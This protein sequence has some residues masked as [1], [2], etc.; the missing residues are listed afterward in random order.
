MPNLHSIYSTIF[1]APG[2][3]VVE[4]YDIPL[5][6]SSI[7]NISKKHDYIPEK[8][9]EAAAATNMSELQMQLL[10]FPLV[11]QYGK[12]MSN[13]DTCL[14]DPTLNMFQ[15]NSDVGNGTNF[16]NISQYTLQSIMSHLDIISQD[17]SDLID[18]GLSHAGS[19]ILHDSLVNKTYKRRLLLDN[20]ERIQLGASRLRAILENMR[21]LGF[22]AHENTDKNIRVSAESFSENQSNVY[23]M[24]KIFCDGHTGFYAGSNTQKYAY[25]MLD[26]SQCINYHLV[27]QSVKNTRP[28]GLSTIYRNVSHRPDD[29]H[30]EKLGSITLYYV[31]T[32]GKGLTMHKK[33]EQPILIGKKHGCHINGITTSVP[34]PTSSI[35]LRRQIGDG[36]LTIGKKHTLF[37]PPV[38]VVNKNKKYFIDLIE[39][40]NYF[41]HSDLTEGNVINYKDIYVRDMVK[42]FSEYKV[43][44]QTE[45]QKKNNDITV[46][47]DEEKYYDYYYFAPTA[48]S[49]PDSV[50]EDVYKTVKK[51][52]R[53]IRKDRKPSSR[54]VA[55]MPLGTIEPTSENKVVKFPG[56][57]V[58]CLMMTNFVQKSLS[59]KCKFTFKTFF[60]SPRRNENHEDIALIDKAKRYDDIAMI[61]EDTGLIKTNTPKDVYMTNYIRPY[62]NRDYIQEE[63]DL[64]TYNIDKNTNDIIEKNVSRDI[65]VLRKRTRDND[66]TTPKYRHQTTPMDSDQTAPKIAMTVVEEEED[67]SESRAKRTRNM[68]DDEGSIPEEG[69]S[70]LAGISNGDNS[71]EEEDDETGNV[72]RDNHY[73][74][75]IKIPISGMEIIYD[76]DDDDHHHS[77]H[78]KTH[79]ISR[80]M[81][82][83]TI[84]EEESTSYRQS[85]HLREHK[86]GVEHL[87]ER[88][89]TKKGQRKTAKK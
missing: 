57:N 83:N 29:I 16:I 25:P 52:T 28:A 60:Q 7:F 3:G 64:T 38:P 87:S 30:V 49:T 10:M 50:A 59:K 84:R 69:A 41:A 48:T 73:K 78:N 43:K 79:Q 58:E 74:P 21:F 36:D 80:Q 13:Y 75:K 85:D 27:T 34:D 47:V 62:R 31:C 39:K 12:S 11:F 77:F 44:K 15:N 54:T 61:D 18:I 53:S 1:T 8:Y 45:Y 68:E 65:H 70:N 20:K 19:K 9:V 2:Y 4:T 35:A 66:Q 72:Q 14:F 71:Q 24:C 33:S 88:P 81:P 89:K 51:Y 37:S 76:D 46:E 5:A 86:I 26:I 63:I 23:D 67:D 32:A 40:N 42:F 22:V 6:S 82:L 56:S 17:Y 55:V